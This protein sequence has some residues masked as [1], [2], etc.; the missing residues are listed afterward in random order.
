MGSRHK[1]IMHRKS[2]RFR[3]GSF[4]DSTPRMPEFYRT[5]ALNSTAW[6]EDLRSAGIELS[7][8]YVNFGAADGVS[9][10]PLSDF[11]RADVRQRGHA[12]AVEAQQELCEAHRRNLPWVQLVCDR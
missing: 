6:L 8:T 5:V 12:L 2:R 3:V 4:W 11:A 7:G 1:R 10:D 9:D